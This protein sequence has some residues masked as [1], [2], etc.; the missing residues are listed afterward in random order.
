M[1]KGKKRKNLIR[2]LFF[3]GRLPCVISGLYWVAPLSL[4]L[5]RSARP[6]YLYYWLWEMKQYEFGVAFSGIIF[7]PDFIKISPGYSELKQTDRP[8]RSTLLCLFRA[9]RA[10]NA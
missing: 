2:C 9:Q 5:H 7:T 8:R 10:K 4:P 6:P 1:E 3:K